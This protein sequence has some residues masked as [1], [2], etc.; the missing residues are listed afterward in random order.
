MKKIIVVFLLLVSFS[1]FS[2]DSCG[3]SSAGGMGF[4]SMLDNNFVGLR[5]FKQSYKSK[6]GIF[7]NSPWIDE[8]FNTVQ[9]W[10]RIPL[11]AKIQLSALIPYH[12][13]ERTLST[14]AQNISGLGDMTLLALY[15]LYQTPM[16]CTAYTHKLNVVGGIKLPTGKFKEMNN[17]ATINQ[18]F[19]LGTG[20]WDYLLLTE[21]VF[22]KKD[23]GLN[24]ML[25]YILKT[26]NDKN[27]K[28]G[29][30]FNYSSTIFYLFEFKN[31]AKIAP[32]LGVAGE[33]Y[34]TNM[35]HGLDV[36]DTAGDILFTKFGLEAGKDKFSI[37]VNVM[38]PV[39]QNLSNGR[40]EANYRW[41]FNLNYTL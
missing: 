2:C 21:Y 17:F 26:Q 1:G 29:N 37:G 33:L 30:Q 36:P 8:K 13:N 20:S 16:N 40:M 41:S 24:T 14:G 25:N 22:K 18:S 11:T 38:L 19:Q 12:F 34:Q 9:A 28:Y 6:N 23:L 15:S 4:S 35:Q 32:Q 10:G 7:A 5:Y 27:Y 31:E 39:S 3:S